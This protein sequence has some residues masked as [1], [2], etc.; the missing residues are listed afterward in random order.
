MATKLT[1]TKPQSYSVSEKLRIVNFAEQN[2]NR[3]AERE[4]GVSES[5]VRL[6]RKRKENLENM[7][8][9]KRAN[10]RKTATWPELEVDLLSWITEKRINGLAILP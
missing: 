2:G 4:F 7:P 5:N 10:R 6:W 8:R 1:A 3:A 9:L